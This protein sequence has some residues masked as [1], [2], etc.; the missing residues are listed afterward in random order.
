MTGQPLTNAQISLGL[1]SH[2]NHYLFSDHYLNHILKSDPRWTT[3]IAAGDSFLAWVTELYQQEQA[4]LAHYNESQLEAHWF[5]PIL[6]Q[7]GHVFE[8]QTAVPGVEAG[9][10]YPDYVFY[11]DEAARQQAIASQGQATATQLA[12]AL[13]EVKAWNV[14]LGK[15]SSGTPSFAN[16]NPSYQIDYYLRATELEWG[17]LSNGRLWRLVH[18]E[19]SYKLDIYFEIDLEQVIVGQ[20]R[21]AAIFFV[22]F[23]RQA[24]LRP[25]AQG[26]VF[27]RDALAA[28][29]AYAVQLENDLRDSAYKALEHLIQGFIEPG[30]NRLSAADLPTIYTNSLYLLYRILFLFYGESWGLLPMTNPQYQAY[31]LTKL[32]RDIG[33]QLDSGQQ[34]PPMTSQYWHRLKTLFSIINGD[35]PDLNA[36]LG[37]PR[38]NGGLFNPDLHSFLEQYFVGDRYLV[39]AIDVLARREVGDKKR[40]RRRENV[41]YRTL[42]VRQLGS[43]YEGLLEYQPR[44]AAGP[45]VAV[46]KGKGEEWLPL[47]QKPKR[48]KEVDTR[49]TG[50]VY[51]VTDKGE[52]KATGS[53]YT[54]DYIVKYI[55]EQT[56]GPLVEAARAQVKARAKDTADASRLFV[57]EILRL[58]VLDPAMGSGHFLVEATDFLARA[59]ATDAYVGQSGDEEDD[60]T[61]WRRQVV[62]A[63]IYGVDK[64]PM[65]VELAKLSLW[66]VTVARDK[67]LSFLDHHLQPGDSLV[68]ARLAD[69]NSLPGARAARAAEAEAAQPLLLDE[70]ALTQDTFKAVGGMIAIEK[71]LSESIEDIQHKERLLAALQAHLQKWRQIADLWTSTA[72][73]NAMSVEEYADLLRHFQGQ[74]ALMSEAQR[75]PFL[76]HPALTGNDYFHWELAFPEVFFDEYG[77]SRGQAAGFDA[78]IG[79]P[80]YVRQEQLKGYKPFFASRFADVYAGTA[81][82]FVYFFKQ[83]LD[84]LRHGG[85]T[86]YISSNSWLRANYATSLRA[87]LRQQTT[88]R[89]LIDLGDNRVFEDAPDLYPAIHIV[90]KAAPENKHLA[91]TAIFTRGEGLYNLA[92]ILENKLFDV[93]IEDQP[94]KGWQLEDRASRNIIANLFDGKPRLGELANIEIN[95]GV[96][97]G[98]N[99]AFYIDTETRTRLI[100]EDEKCEAI[101]KPILRG[102]DLRPWYQDW[103]NQWLIFTRRGID[104]DNFPSVKQHL[105]QY[106][107]RLEPRPHNWDNAEK[108]PGRKPGAYVWYELQDTVDYFE[109]FDKPK[110]FWPGIT[111]VPRFSWNE[112]GEL[113]NDAGFILTTTNKALLSIL[114]S[115]V[116]W[117]CI[118]QICASLGERA[119]LPRYQ[120]KIQFIER[121]PIPEMSND[122]SDSLAQLAASTTYLA[123]QR[124][125]LHQQVRHRLQSDLGTPEQSLNLALTSWWEMDFPAFRS[126][127]KK[128]FKR[129]I[130][131]KERDEWEAYLAE[132]RSQHDHLTAQIIGHETDLNQQVY[133]LF[134]L[135]PAE[136]HLIEESTKYPYGAV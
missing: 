54:P 114:Q 44:R 7:L 83:A 4:Q 50:D 136:I 96:K 95:Y 120:L 76:S 12:L 134:H 40:E 84:Q 129:D 15:K 108:W 39:A 59:I 133:A 60:L 63:C 74:P 5:K 49:N 109:S 52:R 36:H 130:P 48:V 51:L 13:G 71:M 24:A 85:L 68:G 93:L 102:G 30:A 82:L 132:C 55:V 79:N 125:Q 2:N 64:N 106:Q 110:I 29:A 99:E 3:A 66:L 123:K 131:L 75:Q 27:L 73:G 115:R 21:A 9:I 91:Q 57:Q 58:N 121:L 14:P 11:P 23:F 81:D 89:T 98:F 67:P 26:R 94:D 77:R 1:S 6:S 22:L 126:Q 18:K 107:E 72:F 45:M 10:K 124:Y 100:A 78:I 34:S 53:Y 111:K 69:L 41:D 70:T 42:G 88:V 117:F 90:E 105:A 80:P 119:G 37:V 28:S 31:S 25:D 122:E 20:N 62:E 128:V 92:N 47:S 118:S 103:Q 46:K 104:I 65:A 87:Y 19:S 61:Y 35:Q 32:A 116:I 17:V 113:V 101:I 56:L 86:S 38:Y 112:T 135:T 33:R 8:G 43:I 127:I 16:N 97:S